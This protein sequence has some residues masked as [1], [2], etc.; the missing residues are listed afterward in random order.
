MREIVLASAQLSSNS[1]AMYKV[2]GFICPLYSYI[3]S[4]W[5]HEQLLSGYP[6]QFALA[7]NNWFNVNL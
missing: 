2:G 7:N 6:K 5:L 4:I 1:I 3:V